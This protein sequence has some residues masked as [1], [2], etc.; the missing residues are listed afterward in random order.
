M[1]IKSEEDSQKLADLEAGTKFEARLKEDVEE[2][3]PFEK[4][5]ESPDL[6]PETMRGQA[7]MACQGWSMLYTSIRSAVSGAI[8]GKS[9]ESITEE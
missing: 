6:H 3:V 9:R 1:E 7:A 2:P 4:S 5:E 8:H